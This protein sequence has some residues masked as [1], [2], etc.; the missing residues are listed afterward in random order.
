MSKTRIAING[1][2]RIGRTLLREIYNTNNQNL[3]IVAVNNP[4]DIKQYLNLIK[5]DSI[6]GKFLTDISLDGDILKVGNDSIKFFQ[7]KILQ[8]LIGVLRMLKL[9]SMLLVNLK[10]KKV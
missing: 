7:K 6:H 9:S 5:Y 3:Q 1:M 10:I 2:G 8:K 4:G